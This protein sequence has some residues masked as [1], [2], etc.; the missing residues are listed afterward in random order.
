MLERA[1]PLIKEA[2]LP[3]R[4]TCI[5][6]FSNRVRKTPKPC[7]CL[8]TIELQNNNATAAL[9]LIDRAIADPS[10]PALFYNRG[11][12]LHALERFDEAIASY[13]L[14]LASV[15]DYLEARLCLRIQRSHHCSA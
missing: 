5:G 15:P 9:G 7:I 4:P 10:Y 13:D 6:K 14:A 3:K 2:R 8:G 11:V 12:A 1:S